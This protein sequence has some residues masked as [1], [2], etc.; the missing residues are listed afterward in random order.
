MTLGHQGQGRQLDGICQQEK[1]SDVQ[2]AGQFVVSIVKTI[3]HE[4]SNI[5][6][7]ITRMLLLKEPI[8]TGPYAAF[9]FAL[10][11]LAV[12][13]Q[14]LPNLL[15]AEQAVRIREYVFRCISSTDLGSYPRDAI[16]EYQSAWDRCIQQGELPFDGMASILYDKLECQRVVE[17]A[18]AK[19]KD[20]L[21]LMALSERMIKLGGGWW[22]NAVQRYTLVP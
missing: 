1:L 15:S 7:E 18:H 16:S 20:P 14:A 19:L 21:P 9:E 3:Q 2:A 17:F 4:W 6:T 10:A 8:S 22:K 5:A 13:V 12:E 11:V